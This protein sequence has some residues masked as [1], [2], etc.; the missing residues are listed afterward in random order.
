MR[1]N[2]QTLP[3]R[4]A[5]QFAERAKRGEATRVLGQDIFEPASWIY[6]FE[7]GRE[8]ITLVSLDPPMGHFVIVKP[9]R[10]MVKK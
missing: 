8:E 9:D 7:N 3:P 1:S 4:M 6:A 10:P 5:A 2:P